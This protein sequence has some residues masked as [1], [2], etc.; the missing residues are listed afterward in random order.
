MFAPNDFSSRLGPRTC[1]GVGP[2]RRVGDAN[3]GRR[4]N[5]SLGRVDYEQHQNR[6]YIFPGM[7][8]TWDPKTGLRHPLREEQLEQLKLVDE[9]TAALAKL[10]QTRGVGLL[11]GSDSGASNSYRFPGWTLHQEL[12]LLVGSGLSPMKHCKQ[13]PGTLRDSSVNCRVAGLWKR[14]GLRILSCSLRV[15]WKT[16]GTRRRST[17]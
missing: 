2:A 3:P 16:S 15:H 13:P 17:Q 9:K 11:A 8:K 6:K 5:G 12:E 7:W 1:R 14:A 4:A 10:M